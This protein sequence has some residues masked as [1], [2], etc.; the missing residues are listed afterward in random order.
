L[1]DKEITAIIGRNI[2]QRRVLAGLNQTELGKQLHMSFQQVQKYERG[3]N[4]IS[5]LYLYR[6]AAFF[7]CSI[8]SFYD[9]LP[10]GGGTTGP[11]WPDSADHRQAGRVLRA[12][13]EISNPKVKQT[14]IALID[15][16][17]KPSL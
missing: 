10:L 5:A 3:S 6:L 12:V 11:V 2:R 4:N 17:S 1:N 16:L 9:G 15:I 14:I 7:G 13:M 8:E